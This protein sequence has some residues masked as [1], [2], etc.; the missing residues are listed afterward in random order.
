[1]G[2]MIFLTRSVLGFACSMFGKVKHIL[3]NDGNKNGDLLWYKV[4]TTTSYTQ[5]QV[6]SLLN[7]GLDIGSNKANQFYS[8]AFMEDSKSNMII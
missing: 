5:I 8:D 7:V 6:S 2:G 3:P 4:K 1:M